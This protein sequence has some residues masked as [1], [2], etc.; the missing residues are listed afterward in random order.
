MKPFRTNHITSTTDEHD[1]ITI[2]E[3][4]M[5]NLKTW[6]DA[7][8][9]KLNESKTKF[10]YVSKILLWQNIPVVLRQTSFHALLSTSAGLR[11]T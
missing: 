2:I 5:L 4:S 8:R 7:V 11:T 1:T 10:I 6:M 3:K 9:L